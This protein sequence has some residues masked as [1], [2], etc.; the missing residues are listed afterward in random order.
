MYFRLL[1][2]CNK[3]LQSVFYRCL[4]CIL[5]FLLKAILIKRISLKINTCRGLHFLKR[6]HI[7][8][9]SNGIISLIDTW[10]GAIE[11]IYVYRAMNIIQLTNY[12]L[13]VSS[14]ANFNTKIGTYLCLFQFYHWS[15]FGLI[16]HNH[17]STILQTYA[18]HYWH[19]TG[20]YLEFIHVSI[21]HF[22]Q[23]RCYKFAS[24]KFINPIL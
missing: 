1:L 16:N 14:Y 13:L 22:N 21:N 9:N 7:I 5:D 19:I 23:G 2:F 17:S 4:Y 20:Q 6:A 24:I 3:I 18:N 10:N 12:L 8:S 11:F 15:R